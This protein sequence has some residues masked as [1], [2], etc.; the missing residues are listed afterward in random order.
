MILKA[1]C[2][3]QTA[4]NPA[5]SVTVGAPVLTVT[6]TKAKLGKFPPSGLERAIPYAAVLPFKRDM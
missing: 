3:P 1:V 2:C 5:L 4:I 6:A